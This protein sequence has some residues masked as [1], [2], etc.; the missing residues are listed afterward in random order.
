[1]DEIIKIFREIAYEGRKV[2]LLN[3]YKGIPVSYAASI[4]SIGE[5]SV[6]VST[7]KIQQIGRASCRERV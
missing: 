6:T 7:E 4:T 2:R 5:A 3:L 1:M